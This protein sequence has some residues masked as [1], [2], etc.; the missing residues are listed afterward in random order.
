MPIKRVIQN[1]KHF[2]LI[3]AL[4]GLEMMSTGCGHRAVAP[5]KK[6][7][8]SK[9]APSVDVA[10]MTKEQAAELI[11]QW[12]KSCRLGRGQ[13]CYRLGR[14]FQL[15]LH[16]EENAEEALLLYYRACEN[17]SKAGCLLAGKLAL[18]QS[19]SSYSPGKAIAS[20][21]Q[22]CQLK[23]AR[24]CYEA[25]VFW[26]MGE[27]AREDFQKASTYFGLSCRGEFGPA[28]TH[29]GVMAQY[30]IG[31]K[32]SVKSATLLFEKGCSHLDATSCYMAARLLRRDNPPKALAYSQQSCLG[33]DKRGCVIR[34]DLARKD[35]MLPDAQYYY[36]RA[37]QL[38]SGVGCYRLGLISKNSKQLF[39]KAC[40]AD[41][42]EACVAMGMREMAAHAPVK[43]KASRFFEK[44]CRGNQA[45][46]CFQL[47]RL[48]QKEPTL[49]PGPQDLQEA[50]RRAC[51]GGVRQACALP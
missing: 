7:L 45:I 35:N 36:G 28:C 31:L 23:E 16:L 13:D 34:G 20:F 33:D 8:L 49:I 15:G 11:G 51:Q 37:C 2:W 19:R 5:T 1:Y 43:E 26:L 40:G 12:R 32:A 17:K 41:V 18:D 27:E 42:A 48:W 50:K 4:F 44:A 25:G 24:A 3:L 6:V 9:P 39:E 30:G 22:G 47:A 29:L 46:G 14:L 38:E 10:S 21:A